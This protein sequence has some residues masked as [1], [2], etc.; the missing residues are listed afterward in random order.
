MQMIAYHS[1]PL[2]FQWPAIG[3]KASRANYRY[4]LLGFPELSSC[5]WYWHSVSFAAFLVAIWGRRVSI[6]RA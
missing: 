5:H 3:P 2:A 6:V 4:G 1:L